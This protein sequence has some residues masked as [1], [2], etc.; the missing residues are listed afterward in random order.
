MN[1]EIMK[2]EVELEISKLKQVMEWDGNISVLP[3]EVRKSVE[4]LLKEEV[5]LREQVKEQYEVDIGKLKDD[6]DESVIL[7]GLNALEE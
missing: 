7:K 4:R 3:V 6:M 2:E 5:D 1:L